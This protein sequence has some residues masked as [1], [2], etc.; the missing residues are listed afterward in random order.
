[1][2]LR[3][4]SDF[5]CCDKTPW[6]KG[7]MEESLRWFLGPEGESITGA[8]GD[9]AAGGQNRKLRSLTPSLTQKTE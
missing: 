1:M 8:E 5:S 6:P 2:V 9:M 3:V 4:I 7:L